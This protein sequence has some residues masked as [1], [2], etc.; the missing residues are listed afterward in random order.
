MDMEVKLL[1]AI[2]A[3]FFIEVTEVGMVI[4]AKVTQ[5]PNALSPIEVTL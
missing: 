1:Q 5:L 3:E 2:N 4:E